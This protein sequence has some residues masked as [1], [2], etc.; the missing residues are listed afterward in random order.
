MSY[1]YV[2]CPTL[3]Q[4]YGQ[5]S[6]SLSPFGTAKSPLQSYETATMVQVRDAS[7]STSSSSTGGASSKMSFPCTLR[8][9]AEVHAMQ[10]APSRL[11]SNIFTTNPNSVVSNIPTGK[12]QCR[13]PNPIWQSPPLMFNTQPSSLTPAEDL[14]RDTLHPLVSALQAGEN[15]KA[16]AL[17]PAVAF[18]ANVT[19]KEAPCEAHRLIANTNASAA[20]TTNQSGGGDGE[21]DEDLDVAVSSSPNS[22]QKLSRRG[23]LRTFVGRAYNT[24]GGFHEPE[25]YASKI[26]EHASS[27][28]ETLTAMAAKALASAIHDNPCHSI[29]ANAF[30]S[31]HAA[32]L[33]NSGPTGTNVNRYEHS[34][35]GDESNTVVPP[36]QSFRNLCPELQEALLKRDKSCRHRV[37]QILSRKYAPFQPAP[38]PAGGMAG[39]MQ[40]VAPMTDQRR[41]DEPKGLPD[42]LEEFDYV[43]DSESDRIETLQHFASLSL[44]LLAM[45]QVSPVVDPAGNLPH[46]SHPASD[47]VL[48]K[49]LRVI[50]PTVVSLF[51]PMSQEM[52][53]QTL[54]DGVGISMNGTLTQIKPPSTSSF[55]ENKS[56]MTAGSTSVDLERVPPNSYGFDTERLSTLLL[57]K[58]GEIEHIFLEGAAWIGPSAFSCIGRH[59]MNLRLLN[60]SDCTE[61]GDEQVLGI[62]TKCRS[63]GYLNL[64][65][66]SKV[67]GVGIGAVFEHCHDLYALCIGR[68][69]LLDESAELAFAQVYRASKLSILDVS[70][71][72]NITDASIMAVAQHCRMIE[73]IDISGCVLLTDRAVMAL[74]ACCPRVWALKLKLCPLITNHGFSNLTLSMRQL[75]I[76]DIACSETIEPSGFLG[77]LKT[78]PMLQRLTIA[79]CPKLGDTAITSITQYARRLRYLNIASCQGVSMSSLMELVHELT[80]L[81]LVVVSESSIS[82]AEVVMLSAL[83]ESCKIIR[84]QFRPRAPTK[85][86][87]F[88]APIAKPKGGAAPGGKK[89]GGKK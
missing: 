62:A 66:C 36:P 23:D 15:S 29:A 65:G 16:A 6:V 72:S 5:K 34:R 76:L 59:C 14:P 44:W 70:Y 37:A 55:L 10:I 56:S 87:G 89:A 30:Y 58:G 45:K 63:L 13:S 1:P 68:L 17:N 52:Q 77:L 3:E 88:K 42:D 21:D 38:L 9:S 32:V 54:L 18:I 24:E 69:P 73:M 84:N 25:H 31:R 26:M 80:A 2:S 75:R 40:F 79:G 57:D 85:L 27:Q 11:D 82:N 41:R 60:V 71:S 78:I 86:L 51:N 48:A 64:S 39:A 20:R 12:Q 4:L 8:N 19:R 43:S 67:S 61:L 28:P 47:V 33:P 74:G 46:Q 83:R 50:T 81:R 49:R 22:K 35:A 7:N 53:P